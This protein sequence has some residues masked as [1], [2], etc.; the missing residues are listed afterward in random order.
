M[1]TDTQ[2]PQ[3][4]PPST[5]QRNLPVNLCIAAVAVSFVLLVGIIWYHSYYR[6]GSAPSALLVVEG[7]QEFQGAVI[8]VDGP[9]LQEPSEQRITSNSV[10][11]RFPL[12]AGQY[13]IRI[14]NAAG[15]V[16]QVNRFQISDYQYALI[17]LAKLAGARSEHG[18][19]S[20]LP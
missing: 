1:H 4:S 14:S 7:S 12:P 3:S 10:V 16:Y 11:C 2:A 20:N 5:A 13:S 18:D 9:A 15:L 17:P 6:V 19:R 8:T